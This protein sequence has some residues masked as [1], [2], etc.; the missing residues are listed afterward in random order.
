MD[1]LQKP[2]KW[3][4]KAIIKTIFIVLVALGNFTVSALAL[5]GFP[6]ATP[7]MAGLLM[8]NGSALTLCYRV[9]SNLSG[10]IDKYMSDAQT[11]NIKLNDISTFLKDVQSVKSEIQELSP[12]LINNTE[13]KFENSQTPRFTAVFDEK[14]NEIVIKELHNFDAGTREPSSFP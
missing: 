11:M 9:Q 2:K 7:V 1:I 6:V 14:R 10:F 3:T 13:I 5:F 8:L 4:K 12:Q